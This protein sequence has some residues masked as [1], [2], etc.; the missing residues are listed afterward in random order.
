MCPQ[1]TVGNF[2]Q[3]LK[4]RRQTL[5]FEIRKL[6]AMV[7]SQMSFVFFHGGAFH[8]FPGFYI[9][10]GNG[11]SREKERSERKE[12]KPTIRHSLLL[13]PSRIPSRLFV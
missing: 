1:H 7:T 4:E 9:V 8:C 3:F 11:V 5:Q 13:H 2:L 6:Y 12:H 10:S